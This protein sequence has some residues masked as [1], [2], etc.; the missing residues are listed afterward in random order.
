[1]TAPKMGGRFIKR[2]VPEAEPV[3]E[4]PILPPLKDNLFVLQSRL[5][6]IAI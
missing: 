2:L 3:I 5:L 1:M 4:R 6:N